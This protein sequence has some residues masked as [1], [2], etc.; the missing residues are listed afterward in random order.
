MRRIVVLPQPDGPSSETNSPSLIVSETSLT[1]CDIAVGLA[2]PL[3]G[4]RTHRQLLLVRPT[5]QRATSRCQRRVQFGEF[6]ATTS[7][8]MNQAFSSVSP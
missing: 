2:Q 4:Q 1:T 6:L 7:G 3:E 8:S 5:V